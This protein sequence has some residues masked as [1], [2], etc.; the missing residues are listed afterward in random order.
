M[1][2]PRVSTTPSFLI[3]HGTGSGLESGL[4]QQR[5]G[6]PEENPYLGLCTGLVRFITG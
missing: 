3:T 2:F 5:L 1:G 6:A 4:G